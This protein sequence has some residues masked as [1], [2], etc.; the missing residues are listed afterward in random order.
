MA[1]FDS[2]DNYYD[3]AMEAYCSSNKIQ[4]KDINDEQNQIIIER[5]C[6][7]IAFYIVWIINNK[8]EGDIHKEYDSE[9]LEKVRRKEMTGVDFFLTCCDGKLWSDDFSDK[10]LAFTEYYYASKEFMKDYVD[11][12]FNELYDVPCEFNF[13]WD[14]FKKFEYV[15]DRR[16]KTFCEKSK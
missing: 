4:P 12:V 8:L 16:Y 3:K 13:N 7:H 6:V 14:D 15:L 1:V 9:K 2:Y 5:S 11:F 10:G